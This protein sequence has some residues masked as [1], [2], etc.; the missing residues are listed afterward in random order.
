[1]LPV[2]EGARAIE[3]ARALVAVRQFAD[4]EQELL[5]VLDVDPHDRY[6]LHA[7]VDFYESTG[8]PAPAV[9][10][11]ARLIELAPREPGHYFALAAA[12]ERL[13]RMEDVAEVCRRLTAARP[14]LA[15]A[16]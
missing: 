7:L 9:Q 11:L 15:V 8:R 1:M 16:H 14:D 3:R 13:G 6:V 10:M 12:Y 5:R 2:T 4:A